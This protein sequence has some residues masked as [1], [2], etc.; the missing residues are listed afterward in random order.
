MN[1]NDLRERATAVYIAV[2]PAVGD[3]LA[4]HL[5]WAADEIDRLNELVA[6]Q[7]IVEADE[8]K[9]C[10]CPSNRAGYSK[11]CPIHGYVG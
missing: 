11:Y 7:Q 10:V 4:L 8:H 2:G 3:D 6:S 1:T 5:R 9:Q